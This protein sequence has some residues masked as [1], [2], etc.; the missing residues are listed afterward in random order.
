MSILGVSLS[1]P[2]TGKAKSCA[3]ARAHTHHT[4][5]SRQ[6]TV[7][8]SV[9]V[10][11]T[12]LSEREKRAHAHTRTTFAMPIGGG[13]CRW[14][15]RGATKTFV[16]NQ[17][18]NTTTYALGKGTGMI[19]G[20][21]LA[22]SQYRALPRERLGLCNDRPPGL[23]HPGFRTIT[24]ARKS[25]LVGLLGD[26][27]VYPRRQPI[28]SDHWQS[29]IS[30]RARAHTHTPHVSVSSTHSHSVTERPRSRKPSL[31]RAIHT[32]LSLFPSSSS[33]QMFAPLAPGTRAPPSASAQRAFLTH[34][35]HH[36]LS[37]SGRASLSSH[38]PLGRFES[39]VPSAGFPF[40]FSDKKVKESGRT[41]PS[42]SYCFVCVASKR[43]LPCSAS[44]NV[45]PH[46][47]TPSIRVLL[48]TSSS[49]KNRKSRR[50]RSHGA[51]PRG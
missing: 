41:D 9:F 6:L 35:H 25:P 5:P 49:E 24:I 18:S 47:H 22:S 30:A 4:S 50:V 29:E 12:F 40:F 3:R 7:I 33:V 44:E 51:K 34:H 45:P 28:T 36:H 13:F 16:R 1:P 21:D 8:D 17:T 48:Q 19:P 32:G 15:S 14:S 27:Y 2:I 10:T 26:K 31:F 20:R 38:T 43:A 11:R 37:F 42:Y 46:T 23:S 39:A